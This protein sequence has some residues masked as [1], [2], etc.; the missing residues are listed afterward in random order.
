MAATVDLSALGQAVAGIA[1]TVG[2]F[3]G[4]AYAWYLKHKK[5]VAE[6]RAEVAESDAGRIVA[7]AQST[8]YKL[9]TER[10]NTLENDYKQLREELKLE[11]QHGRRLELH[12]W[13]LEGV[14]RDAGIT[15]P[16]FSDSDVVNVEG[17]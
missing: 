4:G 16:L 14:M 7:D 17:H 13:R 6:T 15:P 12:I 2:T 8:V 1:L 5:N 11:R 9:L 10:L 3:A